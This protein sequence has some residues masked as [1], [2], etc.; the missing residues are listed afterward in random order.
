M[1]SPLGTLRKSV[2][3]AGGPGAP[4]LLDHFVGGGQ[5]CFWDG[6]AE[7]VGGLEV[8]DQ[9]NFCELLYW[10]VGRLVAFQNASGIDASLVVSIAEAAAI[11]H[12]SAGHDEL[13]ELKNRGQRMAGRQRRE[14]FRAPAEEGTVADQDRPHTL[15]RKTDEARFEI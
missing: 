8:D 14:L 11:A 10:E 6:E 2:E 13:T 7:G 1:R 9:L 4:R 15:L 12:Q 5:Q 3:P